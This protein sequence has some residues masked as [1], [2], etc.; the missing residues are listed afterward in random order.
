M[1]VLDIFVYIWLSLVCCMCTRICYEEHQQRNPNMRIDFAYVKR[2]VCACFRRN[3][4]LIVE[5]EMTA[6]YSNLECQPSDDPPS[7][8]QN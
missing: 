8:V 3:D 5:N 7:W 6:S 4:P 2:K 1:H